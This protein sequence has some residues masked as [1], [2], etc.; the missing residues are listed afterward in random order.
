M[1]K[2]QEIAWNKGNLV[3]FMKGYW[4]N[5]SLLFIGKNGPTYGYKPTLERYQ[6]GYP[7]TA[8]MGHF[9]STILSMKRISSDC[10]FVLGKWELKSS[11]GNASGHYTLLI[12]KIR[13][14]WV[15]V[16]DHMS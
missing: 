2:A 15:I 4:E 16:A 14:D 5:D 3:N 13:G 8:H 1:L 9:T 10:Y 12:R 11:V 6:K 7:D